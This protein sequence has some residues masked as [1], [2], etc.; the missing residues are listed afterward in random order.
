M[1]IKILVCPHHWSSSTV[2]ILGPQIPYCG[3][4]HLYKN[5][6]RLFH[7][8]ARILQN[9]D[10]KSVLSKSNSF[11][12]SL[13]SN[14]FSKFKEE[15]EDNYYDILSSI[16]NPWKLYKSDS[17]TW[18]KNFQC[19]ISKAPLQRKTLKGVSQYYKRTNHILMKDSISLG[20][21]KTFIQ[22]QREI[23]RA[24]TQ[25]SSTK[26]LYI[27]FPCKQKIVSIYIP[28]KHIIKL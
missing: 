2:Q 10:Y 11:D 7:N 17:R 3:S 9:Q 5:Q 23:L 15:N 26:E 25:N 21:K 24:I 16:L 19:R 18:Q 27:L 22:L 6:R 28:C 8:H 1:V 12:I 4:P 13:P 14:S 20:Y